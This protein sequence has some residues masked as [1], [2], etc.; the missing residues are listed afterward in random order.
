MTR[1]TSDTLFND[2]EFG[3]SGATSPWDMPTPRKQQSRADMLRR[4]LDGVDVP[5]TYIEAF[6]TAVQED[7]S[8]GKVTSSGVAKTLAAAKLNADDQAQIMGILAPGGN[9][10]PIGRDE[11]NVLLAL[12]GLAQECEAVSLDGVDERRRSKFEANTFKD[13]PFLSILTLV[14]IITFFFYSLFLY[15]SHFLSSN[16]LAGLI[17]AS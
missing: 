6:D 13:I 11:F 4:L 15:T 1:S 5:D 8:G 16:E 14:F 12:I 2:D 7:G 9:L 10:D 17:V 3:G